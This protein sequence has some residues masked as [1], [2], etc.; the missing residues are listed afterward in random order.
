MLGG[1]QEVRIVKVKPD[2]DDLTIDIP[3]NIITAFGADKM[4][5]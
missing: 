2:Y 5:A 4:S 1:I 3:I